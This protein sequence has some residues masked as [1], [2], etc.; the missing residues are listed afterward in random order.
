MNDG[1]TR[2]ASSPP[3]QPLTPTPE[4]DPSVPLPGRTGIHVDPHTG[5]VTMYYGDDEFHLP[6]EESFTEGGHLANFKAALAKA[7]RNAQGQSQPTSPA[8]MDDGETRCPVF[9]TADIPTTTLD[10]LLECTEEYLAGFNSGNYIAHVSDR[11]VII[12]TKD[13]TT[14]TKGSSPPVASSPTAFV[15]LSL[16]E[17]RDWF[18]ANI[19][20]RRPKGFMP[21]CFLV[22]DN[23]STEDDSC[24]FVCTQDSAPG[25][26]HSLRCGFEVALQNAVTC[27]VQGKSIEEGL[28]GSFMRSGMT[29]TKGNMKLAQDR[30]LYIEGGEVKLDEAW[31]DFSNW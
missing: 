30:G 1:E 2:S 25:E 22:I 20:Q 7:N 9:C 13:I 5:V 27:G 14:I 17:V 29:M 28:M 6:G 3:S 24:V 21:H 18:D 19:T 4:D 23:E 11:L 31:R 26:L 16:K 10:L 8:T 15:G 12:D